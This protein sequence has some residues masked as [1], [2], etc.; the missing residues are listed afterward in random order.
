MHFHRVT[1]KKSYSYSPHV[2][3]VDSSETEDEQEE[4]RT[5]REEEEAGESSSSIGSL[6]SIG[7][8]RKTAERLEGAMPLIKRKRGRPLKTGEYVG[9]AKPKQAEA[10]STQML[11]DAK[12]AE[13]VTD[14]L[15]SAVRSLGKGLPR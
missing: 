5:E 13:E 15:S 2:I 8:D 4:M 1:K 10:E 9:L 6:A 11:A 14:K 3:N 7:A 12:L